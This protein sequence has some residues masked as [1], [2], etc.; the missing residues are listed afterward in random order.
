MKRTAIVILS[1]GLLS[2]CCSGPDIFKKHS[3]FLTEPYGYVAQ[4]AVGEIKLD[5]VLDEADW[6]EAPY[7]EYFA[8]ISGEGFP[9][10]RF[11]TRAKMLWDDN[12]LYVGAELEEPC[13]WANLTK[14][15]TV[16]YY[17]ND[18][19]VFIDPDGDGQNYFEIELNARENVFDL[20]VQKPYRARTRAFVTFSWDAPGTIIRTHLDGT[21]NNPSDVDRGWTVEMAI[22]REA[23]AAEFDNYLKA[24]NWLRVGFSR[25]EW[26]TEVLEGGRIERKKGADGKY[27]PEDNWTWPS[28]GMI[29]MHMPERWGYVYLSDKKGEAFRYPESRPVERLLWAMFYEQEESKSVSGA[30]LKMVGDFNIPKAELDKLSKGSKIIVEA[31]TETFQISVKAA[32]GSSISIDQNG[33]LCRK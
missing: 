11:R 6:C 10:P 31:T 2:A 13:I 15:D 30:Y 12:Y 23:I 7:T 27:L 24:G 16:V 8:D 17:D 1:A 3:R 4:K 22:P 20:F 9:E 25:V 14:R 21:L 19:E 29:A 18:F 32:D 28:T 5:G 33:Y 26:H